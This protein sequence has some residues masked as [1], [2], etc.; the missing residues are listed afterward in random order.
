MR[1]CPGADSALHSSSDFLR[2][3]SS[4]VGE[5]NTETQEGKGKKENG[6]KDEVMT[7][8]MGGLA[9]RSAARPP[10]EQGSRDT[11]LAPAQPAMQ[12]LLYVWLSPVT[13][14]VAHTGSYCCKAAQQY[15]LK[16][17]TPSSTVQVRL[18]QD[19]RAR[20]EPSQGVS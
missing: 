19:M 1:F 15:P 13:G 11:T 3:G 8:A 17:V 10:P 12:P 6:K 4:D 5:H 16:V 14:L 20:P 9:V 2:C 18:K 7:H